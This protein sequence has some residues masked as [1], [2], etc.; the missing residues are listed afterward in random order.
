MI[1]INV[2]NVLLDSISKK[3]HVNQSVIYVKV[4]AYLMENVWVV[5][6]VMIFNKE[7]VM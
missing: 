3:V 6:Q 4:G 2:Q 5:I 7:N 1:K